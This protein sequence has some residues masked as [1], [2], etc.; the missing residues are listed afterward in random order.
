M[1]GDFREDRDDERT[2]GSIVLLVL[3]NYSRN[4][5][6][7]FKKIAK[8]GVFYDMGVLGNHFD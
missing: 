1:S 6:D 7:Q 3:K 5:R 4:H 2:C 8:R